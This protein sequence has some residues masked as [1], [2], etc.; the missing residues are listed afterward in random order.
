MREFLLSA[1]PDLS[2][3]LAFS[4]AALILAELYAASWV[5]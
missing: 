4:G 5:F 2:E 1:F 3:R